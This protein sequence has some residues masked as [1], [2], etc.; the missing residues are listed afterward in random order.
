[1]AIMFVRIAEEEE[2]TGREQRG[3]AGNMGTHGEDSRTCRRA[4][5]VMS[6]QRRRPL[7]AGVAGP[8]RCQRDA[9]FSVCLSVLRAFVLFSFHVLR[10]L[11]LLPGGARP[12]EPGSCGHGAPHPAT[13]WLMACSSARATD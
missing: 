2:N 7:A 4:L 10:L 9:V 3:D 1:M 6:G 13:P 12:H 11:L 8:P 5:R